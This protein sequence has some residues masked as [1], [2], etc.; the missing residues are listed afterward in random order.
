MDYQDEKYCLDNNIPYIN[1]KELRF[2][3]T[4]ND[5]EICHHGI[6]I[7]DILFMKRISLKLGTKIY[8]KKITDD[9][10]FENQLHKVPDFIEKPPDYNSD[11]ILDDLAKI[12]LLLNND[13]KF[14]LMREANILLS[15][16]S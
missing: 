12:W 16:N 6:K 4:A 5:K 1:S 2:K 7:A 10:I 3:Y 14:K 11:Y 8:Y 13:N 15:N 9:P